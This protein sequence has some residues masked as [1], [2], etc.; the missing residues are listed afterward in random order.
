MRRSRSRAMPENNPTVAAADAAAEQ[1]EG[2]H[3]QD[4]FAG[5]DRRARR[6]PEWF[7]SRKNNITQW[8]GIVGA[9]VGMLV[10]VVV[11]YGDM[12][13]KEA[14]NN[15]RHKAI[16]ASVIAVNQR[17]TDETLR[18]EREQRDMLSQIDLMIKPLRDDV[19]YLRSRL[20]R[21]R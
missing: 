5:Q 20:D 10:S 18:R 14:D 9:I 11:F 3:V 1:H 21:G 19:A 13:Q 12:R 16:E 6:E 2:G 15:A 4:S 17:I 7:Q 8:F